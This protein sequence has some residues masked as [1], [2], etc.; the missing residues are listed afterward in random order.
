MTQN[1]KQT[2]PYEDEIDLIEIV[3]FIIDSKKLIISTIIFFTITSFIYS[4]SLKPSFQTTTILEVGYIENDGQKDFIEE[5]Q[6]LL[7]DLN[8]LKLRKYPQIEDSLSIELI[9][10]RLISINLIS[11]SIE[12]NEKIVNEITSHV[13][14][15]HSK[16]LENKINNHK[17]QIL[18]DIDFLRTEINSRLKVNTDSLNTSLQDQILMADNIFSFK[19]EL[20]SLTNQLDKIDS[21]FKIETQSLK[22]IETTTIKPKIALITMFGLFIGFFIGIFLVISKK[23]L[24]KYKES[25]A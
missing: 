17:Q 4:L 13:F 19:K 18:E 3:K 14:E 9:Q 12:Q 11:S 7:F 24:K 16:L 1:L 8:I 15:R 22:N 21:G 23:L 6:N 2:P 25:Q 20:L 5:T 10:D